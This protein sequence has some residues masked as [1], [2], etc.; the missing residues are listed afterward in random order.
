MKVGQCLT[1]NCGQKVL[2]DS[3][4]CAECR[5]KELSK[6]LAFT[7]PS[8]P[9]KLDVSRTTK[10]TSTRRKRTATSK[11]N[12]VCWMHAKRRFEDNRSPKSTILR[13]TWQNTPQTVVIPI[14]VINECDNVSVHQRHH[15]TEN[16]PDSHL[17]GRNQTD[18]NTLQSIDNVA[19]TDSRNKQNGFFE[20]DD[21]TRSP[22]I[23]T[24]SA[25]KRLFN[26]NGL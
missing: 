8:V 17:I 9:K 14:E 7:P 6:F 13:H 12:T 20:V 5:K 23:S 26:S 16:S 11:K 3:C 25:T 2:E 10:R 22:S 24:R 18:T 21:E 4:W 19:V 15:R 1:P